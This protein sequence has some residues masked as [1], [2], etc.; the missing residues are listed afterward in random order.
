MCARRTDAQALRKPVK[1]RPVPRPD[2]LGRFVFPRYEASL[3]RRRHCLKLPSPGPL[4]VPSTTFRG[5]AW[6]C[7][8]DTVLSLSPGARVP[9]AYTLLRGDVG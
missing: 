2:V 8:D 4:R 9:T 1:S 3:E 7:L 5:V 6:G